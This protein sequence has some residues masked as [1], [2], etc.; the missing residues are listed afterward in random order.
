ML[1]QQRDRPCGFLGRVAL[2]E[3]LE[4]GV[5]VALEHQVDQR[6]ALAEALGARALV[7]EAALPYA[8][9]VKP[10]LAFYERYGSAAFDVLVRRHQ[11]TVYGVCYRFTGEHADASDLTQDAFVR[12]YRRAALTATAGHNRY[13]AA[14][15]AT[16]RARAEAA[17]P[18]PDSQSA[19]PT[20]AAVAISA[21]AD[22][23]AEPSGAT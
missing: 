11:Q 6:E 2:V 5:E 12:A 8:A 17:A 13:A 22:S 21:R 10:N 23:A 4:D 7:L 16:L 19:V 15:A 9:A 1:A 3:P 20:A 18:G 14:V